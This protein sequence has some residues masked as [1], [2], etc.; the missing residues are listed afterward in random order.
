MPRARLAQ[1]ICAAMI[2]CLG[3]GLSGASQA[4]SGTF[5]KSLHTLE[6][7][8]IATQYANTE[9]FPPPEGPYETVTDV[10]LPEVNPARERVVRLVLPL[11]EKRN[12]TF[13]LGVPPEQ[14]VLMGGIANGTLSLA[15]YRAGSMSK[16]DHPFRY[17]DTPAGSAQASAEVPAWGR[18]IKLRSPISKEATHLTVTAFVM[19][20]PATGS[21]QE[22]QGNLAV[23]V[24]DAVVQGPEV[25]MSEPLTDPVSLKVS[26]ASW[27][28]WH[29][30]P[31][32][33]GS[34]NRPD[35]AVNAPHFDVAVVEQRSIESST[36]T[37]HR[38]SLQDG[39]P[40]DS[41]AAAVFLAEAFKQIDIPAASTSY[42]DAGMVRFRRAAGTTAEVE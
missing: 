19:P 10:L 26:E 7:G 13:I 38:K 30:N 9:T 40:V 24:H 22:R 35:N 8:V 16:K 18:A 39:L 6:H 37:R 41:D 11:N 32:R 15:Y 27:R 1:Q 5:F 4:E 25:L 29:R 34:G 28:L 2:F 23:I 42:G 20:D 33:A 17:G 12:P 36:D 14:E 31:I 3:A 21:G